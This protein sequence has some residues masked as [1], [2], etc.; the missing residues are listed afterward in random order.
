MF[1]LVEENKKAMILQISRNCNQFHKMKVG[2]KEAYDFSKDQKVQNINYCLIEKKSFSFAV[3]I[4][5]VLQDFEK[6]PYGYMEQDI[7]YLLTRPLLIQILFFCALLNLSLVSSDTI[8]FF[9]ILD[10]VFFCLSLAGKC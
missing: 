5:S 1:F 2:I 4:R 3:T 9:L 6:A 7:I 8:I 10:N